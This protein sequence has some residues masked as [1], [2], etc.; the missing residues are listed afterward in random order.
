MVIA[1][2]LLA[3]VVCALGLVLLRKATQAEPPRRTFSLKLLW[4][5][6]RHRPVWSAGIAAIVAGFGLQVTA[7]ANGPVSQVQLIMVMELPFSLIL[8]RLLLGG[9]LRL[10]EWSAV[11]AMTLGVPTVLL[12]LSPHG[13]EVASAGVSD[14]ILGLTVTACVVAAALTAGRWTSPAARTA[15]A[16]LAAGVL[17]G[18]IA[19]LVKAVASVFPGGLFA[20]LATWHT[21][22]LL[23]T[24][25]AGFLLLQNALQA[26]RLV[27][28]QPGITLANPLVAAVWGIAVFDEQV[29]MG[30]W[31]AGAA[32]GAGA[33]VAGAVL[34]SRSPLL[35][36]HREAPAPQPQVRYAGR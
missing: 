32:A 2:V 3:A 25:A 34:L 18:L 36:G 20:V 28:S 10:R 35:E 4:L 7:L 16:G 1:L 23:V 6:I 5:L 14:W 11:S 8:S 17:A 22:A 29:H 21:W 19:V 27:A 9:R 30:W 13:G 31:L 33:L 26:G 24:G 12:C 15:L